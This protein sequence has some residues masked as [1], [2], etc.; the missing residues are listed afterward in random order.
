MSTHPPIT[1]GFINFNGA[2]VI[3]NTLR[4][5]YNSDY[6]GLLE[7][8]VVDDCSSDH[9]PQ[10][11]REKFPDV[12]LFI[13]PRNMGPNAARNRILSQATHPYVFV[14]DNDIELAPDCLALLVE[15]LEANQD[16]AVA[17]PMVLDFNQRDQVYS[18]GAGLHYVCFGIISLR[19]EKLPEGL[20]ME[21][22]TS[23]CGSGGIMM[24]KR[25]VA[26]GLGG[27]DEDFIF[28]YDDGEFT[29]RVSVSGAL[30]EQVP[31]AKIYHLEKPGRNPKRL[32]YQIK[33]RWTLI[34]KAYSLRSLVLLSP[35]L[36]LFE[37]AQALFLLFKGQA[38][39]WLA[40]LGMVARD[41]GAILQ[42]RRA[43]MRTKKAP[44][45]R[46]LAA[47]EIF[48]FP[49]RVGGGAVRLA[50]GAMELGLD[51]YWKMVSPLLTR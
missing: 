51:I 10:I 21:P 26:L 33:G 9:S 8:M 47:G 45:N 18:N 13:Q 39:E 1:I 17:T 14:S 25:D 37:M 38:G 30:V 41:M 43:V 31:A 48:M 2:E 11:I 36:L 15:R 12:R 50:K 44:D 35:A 23:V 4:A 20:S 46:L 16:T 22:F 24:V 28:G 7:I 49:S 27:F 42:K 40:G 29:Y 19:H 6:N 34:L 5:V 3:E 32:R